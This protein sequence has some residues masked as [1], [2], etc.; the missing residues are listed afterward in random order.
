MTTSI[1]IFAG[2]IAIASIS[3]GPNIVLIIEHAVRFGALRIFPT[4]LGNLACLL[5]VAII[6]AMGVGV[7]LESSPRLFL[8]LKLAGA[9]YLGYVGLTNLR[10]GLRSGNDTVTVLDDTG[11]SPEDLEQSFT[12]R[13]RQAFLISATNP[14]SVLFLGSVFPSFIDPS[15]PALGQFAILFLT[16]LCVVSSIHLGYALIAERVSRLV[17]T[18]RFSRRIKIASGIAFIVFALIIIGASVTS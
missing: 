4:I 8:A 16:L 14:K 2:M 11:L 5:L 7:V 9:A 18:A 3:P 1:T 13:F 6:A 12:S 15:Q 17:G 10:A